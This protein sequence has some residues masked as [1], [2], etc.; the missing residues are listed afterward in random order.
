MTLSRHLTSAALV[1]A[2]AAGCSQSLFD[3]NLG[4]R[5]GG[6]GPADGSVERDAAGPGVDGGMDNFPRD[7]AVQ[8]SCPEPCLADAV[9]NYAPVQ[10]IWRYSET[11]FDGAGLSDFREMMLGTWNSLSAW[12][13]ALS[14]PAIASCPEHAGATQ[15]QGVAEKLLLVPSSDGP[16]ASQ[17]A[18]VWLAPVTGSLRLTGDWRTPAGFP[19]TATQTVVMAR[20][21]LFDNVYTAAFPGRTQPRAF[22]FEVDVVVGDYIALSVLPGD[23]TNTPLGVSFYVTN[24]G[25]ND[26]C[27]MMARFEGE[28]GQFLNHCDELNTFTEAGAMATTPGM[29][30]VPNVNGARAFSEQS[31][32]LYQGPPI[33][34]SGDWTL[35][36][37]ATL[38]GPGEVLSDQICGTEGDRSVSGGISIDVVGQ[39]LHVRV[40]NGLSDAETCSPQTIELS[41]GP[42]FQNPASWHFFRVV[43]D[44]R[45]GTVMACVDGTY[46]S[47]NVRDLPPDVDMATPRPL[48]LG[49]QEGTASG[50]FPGQIADLRVFSR[51]L[52]CRLPPP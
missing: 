42:D 6:Q 24:L 30:P 29:P 21:N 10:G 5:D 22:D 39:A 51:A 27:Q 7:A 4:D 31:A 3:A 1:S 13:G 44:K 19:S 41:E 52:P 48:R 26:H 23:N 8:E 49:D 50:A 35:Q 47:T 40:G 17:P 18:L 45:A 43:R 33:D 20:N 36:F 2:L 32:L 16:L 9:D 15:C 11:F 46:R 34:Y 25:R 12:V 37:W 38:P 14:L 28:P